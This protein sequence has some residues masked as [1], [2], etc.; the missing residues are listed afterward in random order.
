MDWEASFMVAV[1]FLFPAG[2]EPQNPW[3]EKVPAALE[4]ADRTPTVEAY[5][6]AMDI[7]YRAD[8]WRAGLKLA[9]SGIEKFPN[10]STLSGMIARALWRGG[11]IDEAERVVDTINGDTGDHIALTTM[12]EV[13]LARGRLERAGE[14]ARR[15]EKLG[16]K[17]ALEF[18]YLLSVRLSKDKLDGLAPLLR[19]AVRM[20]DPD[21][22]YP[23]MYLE[24]MLDG[25]PEFFAAI[26]PEAINQITRYGAA[27]MPMIPM[28]RLPQCQA[29]I[30][31]EGPYRL[32]LDTGGSITLSLDD[33]V[34]RELELKSYGT[35]SI[36]GVSGKQDSEQCLV[37]EL[38]IG[39]IACRRVM[40][41]TFAMPPALEM[42]AD[43][44]IGTGVFARARMTLDFAHARLVVRASSDRA[45]TGNPAEVRIVGDAKLMAP[46]RL[47][48]EYAIALLD[49][50]ADVA[51]VSPA[52]L[53]ELFPNHAFTEFPASGL[54]VGEGDAPGI[55]LAPGVKLEAWGRTYE[56]YSG[57]G[58]DA[59]DTLL[60][61]IIG[62]QTQILLGMPVFREMNS[63]TIDYPH[64]RMWVE[65]LDDE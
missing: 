20:V 65:W 45:A 51:A 25:L 58:L 64:R 5:R 7:A 40:T 1:M 35:A 56:D 43:G 15:L 3:K 39:E 48:D 50:G 21:N 44:I 24:E 28:I 36:R 17:S 46:V 4:Q 60:S 54:G 42:A 53:K 6:H 30:N 8:D 61:P 41:R 31:G 33:D 9:R 57:L 10:E 63:W 18:Y 55:S 2:E 62:I 12:I 23:E 29:T 52:R 14:A 37:D 11:A 47:Q 16:P 22:G 27:D 59:L 13:E 26:G 38:R 19:Q 34:A 32:I 49:S